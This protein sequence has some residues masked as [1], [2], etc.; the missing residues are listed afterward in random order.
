MPEELLWTIVVSTVDR[1][2]ET[3]K[4]Y[5][6]SLAFDAQVNCA[7]GMYS[8]VYTEYTVKWPP[9]NVRGGVSFTI[10]NLDTLPS[11]TTL[12]SPIVYH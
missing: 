2:I 7:A 10:S 11:L 4:C 12:P 8:V 9:I 3:H 6:I 5:Q 1:D